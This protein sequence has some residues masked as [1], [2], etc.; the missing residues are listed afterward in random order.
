MAFFILAA[1]SFGIERWIDPDFLKLNPSQ[2]GI[3]RESDEDQIKS[4][5][6]KG[7]GN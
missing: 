4:P 2:I 6:Y 3:E 1:I 5:G 7:F